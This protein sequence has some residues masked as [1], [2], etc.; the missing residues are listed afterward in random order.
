MDSPV[1]PMIEM[2]GDMSDR[3]R[4]IVA[5]AY[6]L[7]DEAGL[8]GLTIRAV[9]TRTGLARRAFY[10]RFA[11][12]DDL[13]LAVFAHTLHTAAA[14]FAE[15][16]RSL[17]DPIARLR[18]IIT[19]IVLGRGTIDPRLANGGQRR[20]AAF[21]R[22]HLRLAEARPAELHRAVSP[23]IDLIATQLG[24][25]MAVGQVRP[26]PVPRLA[27]L[28]YNLVSATVHTELL[29]EEGTRP[30]IDRRTALAEEIWE[31]CRRAIMA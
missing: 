30:D 23:L 24:E 7:L 11:G 3:T 19:S 27:A 5:A 31:F 13:V 26:A 4:L 21:S 18:Y 2:D 12:K 8:E 16:V 6:D 14:L 22:E 17:P 1:M 10:D 29:A 20:G 25:G 9:L 28:V 15:Q